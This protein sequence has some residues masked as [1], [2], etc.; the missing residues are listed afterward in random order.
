VKRARVLLALSPLF[1]VLLAPAVRAAPAQVPRAANA[2]V[3]PVASSA[4]RLA[5]LAERVVKLDAQIGQGI[6]AERSKRALGESFRDF[7]AVHRAL[8]SS[9]PAPELRE[10]LQ[11]LALLWQ[12]YRAAA[13]RAPTRDNARKLGERTEEIVWVAMKAAR[14]LQATPRADLET[15]AFESAAAC[16]LAQRIARL[17]LWRRWGIRDDNLLR[18]LHSSEARLRGILDALRAVAANTPEIIAELQVA[19][20]QASFLAQ[21]SS[22]LDSG[23]DAQRHLE[24]V[25][26]AGDHIVESLER[27]T[28][29][30][31]GSTLR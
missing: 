20:N 5:T 23:R 9:A 12:D 10:A 31:E 7:E 26:K 27:V 2:L 14:L 29:L 13:S 11:L 6:L 1:L 25:A 15:R 19:E 22:Q 3:Q 18:E 30:Y 17:H 8:L 28:R 24:F 16:A 4:V 21:A